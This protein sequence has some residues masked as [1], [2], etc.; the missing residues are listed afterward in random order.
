MTKLKVLL[1]RER[2]EML[3]VSSC[4][5]RLGGDFTRFRSQEK[6][7]EYI[8]ADRRKTMQEMGAVYMAIKERFGEA[9]EVMTMDPRNGFP[10]FWHL[11]RDVLAYRPPWKKALRVLTAS[12]AFPAVVA[13][14]KLITSGELEDPD[15]ILERIEEACA[16]D[17]GGRAA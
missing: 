11:G 2:D 1:I 9:A 12:F 4:C 16:Q 5:P 15:T 10:L 17:L 14:G 7:V 3:L 8:F 13:N 6:G